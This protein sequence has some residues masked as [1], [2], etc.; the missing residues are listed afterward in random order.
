MDQLK[1][2]ANDDGTNRVDLN[3]Q[4]LA[5]FLKW[6]VEAKKRNI[7]DKLRG[8]NG[9]T[10][11]SR[12]T[13]MV[14]R[15]V[16]VGDIVPEEDLV[17]YDEVYKLKKQVAPNEKIPVN[18]NEIEAYKALDPDLNGVGVTYGDVEAKIL[19]LKGAKVLDSKGDQSGGYEEG[20]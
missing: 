12:R 18:D 11:N 4:Q 17:A 3:K 5:S 16:V 20:E 7:E 15:R 6:Q 19:E 9:I 14:L 13:A 8:I 2:L 10:L 1:V